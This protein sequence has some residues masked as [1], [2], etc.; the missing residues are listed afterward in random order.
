MIT[1]FATII[2]ITAFAFI[3][4]VAQAKVYD[5][6]EVQHGV[7]DQMLMHSI[8]QTPSPFS[9][10]VGSFLH[11]A[12]SSVVPHNRGNVSDIFAGNFDILNDNP[13]TD[14]CAVPIPSPEQFRNTA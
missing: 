10:D 8:D 13:V 4:A 9:C 6:S 14:S 12:G 1:K 2:S 5:A 11:P 3:G 7:S